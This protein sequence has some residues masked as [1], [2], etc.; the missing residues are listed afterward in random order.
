MGTMKGSSC[1]V[2]ASGGREHVLG[3]KDHAQRH[4][5]QQDAPGNIQ[6]GRF[7]PQ[8]VQ[9]EFPGEE[10]Q[11][12]QAQ[13]KHKLPHQN[14]LLLGGRIFLQHSLNHRGQSHGINDDEQENNGGKEVLHGVSR[15]KRYGRARQR[16]PSAAEI[17]PVRMAVFSTSSGNGFLYLESDLR[18]FGRLCAG[19]H[20]I[21]RRGNKCS[22]MT[23]YKSSMCP[24]WIV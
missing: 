4:E 22:R 7:Q 11:E 5:E 14:G 2:S 21:F 12:Q 9:Q 13:G 20:G 3:G 10:E 17:F 8:Q 1:P 16:E 15:C 18:D 6:G 24:K 23:V 19:D